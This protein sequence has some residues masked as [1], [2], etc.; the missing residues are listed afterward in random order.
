MNIESDCAWA[1]PKDTWTTNERH[2]TTEAERN[3]PLNNLTNGDFPIF[4]PKFLKN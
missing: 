1:V 2:Y 3:D 4:D